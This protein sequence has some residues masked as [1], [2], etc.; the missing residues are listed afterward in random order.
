MGNSN[1]V[2][3]SK[4]NQVVFI[5]ELDVKTFTPLSANKVQTSII[6][7]ILTAQDVQIQ[8]ILGKNLYDK[9]YAEWVNANYD[10]NQLPVGDGA[11]TP[12]ISGDTTNY[13]ELYEQIKLPLIWWSYTVSL[14][15]I[16]IK[17]EEAG[18]MLN[19]TDYSESSGI[20]GLDRLVAEARNVAASYTQTLK[21]YICETFPQANDTK[22]VGTNTISVFVPKKPWHNR[23][24]CGC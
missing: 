23:K 14:P 8:K 7:H 15:H 16:A 22:N 17:V 11:I 5:T 21:E 6:N 19:K 18:I 10:P 4:T 1:D 3:F 24:N 13:R 12:I 20:V 2:V 9:L